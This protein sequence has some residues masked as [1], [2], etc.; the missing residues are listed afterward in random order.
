MRLIFSFCVDEKKI[1][2]DKKINTLFS[3]FKL[4]T[5]NDQ[6]I[7]KNL[8]LSNIYDENGNR[9]IWDIYCYEDEELTLSQLKSKDSFAKITRFYCTLV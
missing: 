4:K 8:D 2:S 5:K 6:Y 7:Y 1:L 3:S 9:H